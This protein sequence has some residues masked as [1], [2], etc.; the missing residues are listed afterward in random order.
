MLQWNWKLASM[1]S[2]HLVAVGATGRILPFLSSCMPGILE[3]K[4][5]QYTHP[6]LHK[7]GGKNAARRIQLLDPASICCFVCL[8]HC[9]LLPL[10]NT[11]I[12]KNRTIQHLRLNSTDFHADLTELDTESDPAHG[13]NLWMTLTVFLFAAERVKGLEK[14]NISSFSSRCKQKVLVRYQVSKRD[15]ATAF[16]KP[17]R[18]LSDCWQLACWGFPACLLSAGGLQRKTSL[19]KMS[20]YIK[21]L[22][23]I[24]ICCSSA[25]AHPSQQS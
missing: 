14:A 21:H 1:S 9:P 18:A 17:W 15:W 19:N 25:L 8:L 7:F 12:M 3:Q 22:N 6:N 24:S 23:N 2:K 10:N 11:K 20:I 4:K 5:D 13:S 16:Q